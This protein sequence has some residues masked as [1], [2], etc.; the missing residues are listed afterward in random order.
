MLCSVCETRFLVIFAFFAMNRKSC[1]Y[2]R[3]QAGAMY[4][5]ILG[6]GLDVMGSA[7]WESY[8][9]IVR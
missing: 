2:D 6:T 8:M 1:I 7:F 4:A 5:Y 3:R 9:V